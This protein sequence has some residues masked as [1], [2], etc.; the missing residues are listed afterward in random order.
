MGQ[1]FSSRHDKRGLPKREELS[2]GEQ[3]TKNFR[4]RNSPGTAPEAV[5]FLDHLERLSVRFPAN[6]GDLSH[7]GRPRGAIDSEK[8]LL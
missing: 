2:G 6:P 3:R 8:T 4:G 7:T 5:T 1:E